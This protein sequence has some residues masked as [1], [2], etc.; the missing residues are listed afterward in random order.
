MWYNTRRSAF[1]GCSL[2]RVTVFR[3]VDRL[4]GFLFSS[5]LCFAYSPELSKLLSLD[6]SIAKPSANGLNVYTQQ[7]C[8][9]LYA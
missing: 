6:C 1:R 5:K 9:F 2:A 4:L 7:R 3:Q 8:C